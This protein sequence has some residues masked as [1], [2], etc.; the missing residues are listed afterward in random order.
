MIRRPLPWP[1]PDRTFEIIARCGAA[2]QSPFETPAARDAGSP[3]RARDRRRLSVDND[4]LD[5][6]GGLRK[7]RHATEPQLR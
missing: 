4:S 5:G 6:N 3:A 2:R 7:L 1:I